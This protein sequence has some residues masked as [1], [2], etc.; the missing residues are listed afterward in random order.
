MHFPPC[1]WI[2]G[3]SETFS[4]AVLLKFSF[5]C[6]VS[7]SLCLDFLFYTVKYW[8]NVI[9]VIPL[10]FILELIFT[11]F[12]KP[13]PRPLHMTNRH[14]DNS[15]PFHLFIFYYLGFCFIWIAVIV[16]VITTRQL[17]FFSVF[18][19]TVRSVSIAKSVILSHHS[20]LDT[21]GQK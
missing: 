5:Y 15:I 9:W 4:N 18:L 6:Y 14:Q 11:R 13:L 16:P 17:Q 7:H 1:V 2:E 10:F 3:V 8:L 19:F 20:R 21:V 12:S